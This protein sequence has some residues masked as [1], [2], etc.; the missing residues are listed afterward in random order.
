[1]AILGH[2]WP[3]MAIGANFSLLFT[4]KLAALTHS[5]VLISTVIVTDWLDIY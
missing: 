5:L 4:G 2:V 3:Q 1:M